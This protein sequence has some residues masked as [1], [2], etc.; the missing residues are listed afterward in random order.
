MFYTYTPKNTC[1]T[2]IEFEIDNGLVKKVQFAGGC[3]GNLKAV[4]SLVEGLPYEEVI[5]KLSGIECGFRG[6]SCSDQLTIAIKNAV[7]N[8][9]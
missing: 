5:Q 6:T 4:S 7:E 2:K 3:N 9:A 1:S 8:N